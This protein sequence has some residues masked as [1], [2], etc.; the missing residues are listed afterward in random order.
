MVGGFH[1]GTQS[2]LTIEDFHT[3]AVQ[4]GLVLDEN[5][6]LEVILQK[7][8]RIPA[9]EYGPSSKVYI[10]TANDLYLG[11]GS[12]LNVSNGDY[13][14][15]NS[16]TIVGNNTRLIVDTG[17]IRFHNAI[18]NNGSIELSGKVENTGYQS[19]GKT[20]L[21]LSSVVNYGTINITGDFQNGGNP[22]ADGIFD[23]A[24]PG[25][26]NLINYGGTIT[27]SGKLTNNQALNHYMQTRGS[28]VQI[29]GGS[30]IVRG[31]MENNAGNTLIFGAYNG[32][33]G[34]LEG[35]LVNQGK[36]QV[37]IAGANLGSHQLITGSVTGNTN[38]EI[39]TNGR[40]SEFINT[41]MQ[42]NSLSIQKNTA[43][44]NNFLSS[45]S[46]TQNQ[47]LDALE[48]SFNA[49]SST[50]SVY[51]YGNRAYL[52]Q[53][54][55]DVYN[56]GA[57]L[58]TQDS[59]L[60][61]WSM[62]Q[63]NTLPLLYAPNKPRSVS[64]TPFAANG[65]SANLSI[66]SYGASLNASIQGKIHHLSAFATYG[67]SQSSNKI[68]HAQTHL[69]SNTFLVG[70]YDRFF[71]SRLELTL[72]GYYGRTAH[73]S[74]REIFINQSTFESNFAYAEMGLQSTLGYPLMLNKLYVKPFLG[75]EY[76]LGLQDSL[77]EQG[78]SS[79]L[80]L[81][82]NAAQ[83][84]TLAA[85]L[86]A[87]MRYYFGERHILFGGFNVQY[88]FIQNPQTKAYVGNVAL[89]ND[90]AH[91]LGY[92]LHLGGSVPLHRNF[93]L[94]LYGLYAQSYKDFKSYSGT[95]SLSYY[96]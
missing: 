25:A 20:D 68:S 55:D 35:N 62:L 47:I 66:P 73:K 52:T 45:V 59:S 76:T 88:A 13:F 63:S 94:I 95:L 80:A 64:I 65:S 6:T 39:L 33:L 29:Y 23:V 79:A 90:V 58:I 83:N 67:T 86:G 31:G 70:V 21:T 5:A 32:V 34:K 11:N 44:I 77:K 38:F 7:G 14:I 18:Q 75:L 50:Q 17:I 37:N 53:L 8:Q 78:T 2:K 61:L 16:K 69:D 57:P 27:I 72:L 10:G 30:I 22:T 43:A 48:S 51:T 91:T 4:R 28:S 85:Q 40:K 9:S 49:Q 56:S 82:R 74:K 12:T 41:T 60:S 87:Q 24:N 15:A 84:H 93:S 81:S 54:R 1:I 96:F 36:V 3:L 42:G 71:L 89:E 26:G 19:A 46:K 92:T